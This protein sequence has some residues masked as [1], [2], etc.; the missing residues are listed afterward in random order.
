MRSHFAIANFSCIP[1]YSKG[2]FRQN[3]ETNTPEACAPRNL[4]ANIFDGEHVNLAGSI[5]DSLLAITG[6]RNH[7]DL[8]VGAPR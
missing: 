8:N 2:S 5:G 6:D 1:S 3:A 4:R 7:F